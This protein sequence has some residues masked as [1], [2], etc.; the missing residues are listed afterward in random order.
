MTAVM[1]GTS[2]SK[3]AWRLIFADP[4]DA[5]GMSPN[6]QET[7]AC[8][9][10]RNIAAVISRVDA[11][12]ERGFRRYSNEEAAKLCAENDDMLIPCASVD[13]HKGKAEAHEFGVRGFSSVRPFRGFS[14]MIAS[15][16]ARYWG[17]APKRA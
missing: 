1:T 13:P 15:L 14:R 7:A 11:E 10:E 4:A 6:V 16:A 17:L 5:N 8:Y 12:H 3:P 2:S 9:R